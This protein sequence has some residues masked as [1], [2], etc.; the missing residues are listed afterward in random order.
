VFTLDSMRFPPSR[1]AVS[2][3]LVLAAAAVLPATAAAHQS[4]AGCTSTSPNVQF[5]SVHSEANLGIIHRNGDVVEVVPR[6]GNNQGANP[7]DLENLTL[8]ISFPNPD[9]TAGPATTFTTDVDLPS[10]TAPIEFPVVEHTVN[11]NDGVFRGPVTIAYSGQQHVSNPDVD[12]GPIGSS[13]R[14]L[15]ISRPHATVSVTPTPAS[16]DAP[17][18][19][20]Y[21]YSVNNDSPLNPMD[22]P[23]DMFPVEVADDRCSSIT[24]TGG[25]TDND[26][27]PTLDRGETWTYTCST[28]FPGG[29]F[30]NQVTV[31]GTSVRDGRPWPTATAQGTVNANGPDMTLAKSHAGDFTQGDSGRTYTLIAT[32][33]GNRAA[34][35]AVSVADTL[36]TGL[37]A[38]A[39]AGDGWTCTLGTLTC[40]R[41][42]TLAAGASYPPITVT[43]DVAGDAPATVVNTA[44]VTRAGQNTANDSTSDTAAVTAKPAPTPA[45]GSPPP[46]GGQP[47]AEPGDGT[48]V[49]LEP[50]LPAFTAARLTNRTFAVDTRGA[51]EPLVNARAKKGTAFAYALNKPARVVFVIERSE[52]GRLVGGSCRRQTR[53]NRRRRACTRFV[54]VGSYA[55]DGK[56][57]A[58]TRKWSGKIRTKAL[59]PATYRAS[60]TARDDAGF[61]SASRRLSFKIV[62]R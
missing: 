47:A 55:Q 18:G 29:A 45:G 19:V 28:T 34:T 46:G 30:T 27:P 2:T 11:F 36:P 54:K 24:F 48:F 25:N 41:G 5:G 13:G 32:N 35:G 7:C 6:V 26:S 8:T 4:P 1:P 15:V 44:S 10:G 38:T 61:T 31:N 12:P 21:N 23:T 49:I 17:L 43:V 16:G 20:T 51:A 60:L 50:V 59:K 14:N 58:N 57:G 39:I 9:G 40:M 56:L 33:S 3:C 52:G 42:D 37:T 53:S 22:I 62:S